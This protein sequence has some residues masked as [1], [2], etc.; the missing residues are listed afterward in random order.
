MTSYPPA[1]AQ[2]GPPPDPPELPEG[3]DPRPRW[4]AW[5]AP[6]GFAVALAG[7]LLLITVLGAA[8]ALSGVDVEK[9]TPPGLT[10]AGTLIQD[11]ILVATAIFFA[12]RVARP[13]AWHFGLRPTR[14]WPA[15]G[16]T[17]LALLSFYLFAAAYSALLDPDAEQTIAEDLGAGESAFLLIVG[18]VVVIVLAPVAEEFFFRGFF[19][20]ALRSRFGVAAAATLDGALFGLIHFTG[21]NTLSILPILAVLGVVFCLVYER[22]GSLYPVIALHAFNNSIAYGVATGESPLVPVTVGI[23]MI[24]A[25]VV[26]PRLAG[27]PA[28]VVR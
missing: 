12:S 8:A 14:F 13:R 2:P 4:P 18:A 6:L 23:A 1:L 28:A 16:W 7:A 9:D 5:Y 21:A 11:A 27:G 17:A 10:I 19:Y 20:R 3:V 24:S 26:A 22:T 15:L 25:C